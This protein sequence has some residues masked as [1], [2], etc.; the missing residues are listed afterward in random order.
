VSV[1]NEELT[2]LFPK[3]V[4]PVEESC[5]LDLLVI[6]FV[7]P[8]IGEENSVMPSAHSLED[9]EESYYSEEEVTCTEEDDDDDDFEFKELEREIY[10]RMGGPPPTVLAAMSKKGSSKALVPKAAPEPPKAEPAPIARPPNPFGGGANNA[11]LEQIKARGSTPPAAQGTSSKTAAPAVETPAPARPPHPLMGG[12]SGG[13]PLLDQIKARG[14]TPPSAQSSGKV[15]SPPPPAAAPAPK[16]LASMSMAE[17]VAAMAAKRQQRLEGT[18]TESVPQRP[19][20]TNPDSDDVLAAQVAAMAAKRQQRM[21]GGATPAASSVVVAKPA[22]SAP[23]PKVVPEPSKKKEKLSKKEKK[24]AK[25]AAA[26]PVVPAAPPAPASNEVTIIK[27]YKPEPLPLP[28][29][30]APVFTQAQ[31]KPVRTSA[32]TTSAV[33]PVEAAPEQH[34]TTTTTTTTTTITK[35]KRVT[36]ADPEYDVTEYKMGCACTVM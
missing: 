30:A 9:D 14:A 3:C 20:E 18:P 22:V 15:A 24:A 21:E 6:V 23:A 29:K 7:K 4:L 36:K 2:L 1:Q 17:Q 26:K 10:G 27:T 11:L 12:G 33:E 35:T 16:P 31:L 34:L 32:T 5:L 25:A 28:E 19:E 8:L 13:N